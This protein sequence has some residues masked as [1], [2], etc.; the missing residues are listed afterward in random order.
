MFCFTIIYD[1]SPTV[2][3]PN[4]SFK[5]KLRTPETSATVKNIN[6]IYYDIYRYIC[7]CV[8]LYLTRLAI[9]TTEKERKKKEKEERKSPELKNHR[10]TSHVTVSK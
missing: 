1:S 2:C 6:L 7:V 8:C 4:E 5:L 3:G 10:R 9:I